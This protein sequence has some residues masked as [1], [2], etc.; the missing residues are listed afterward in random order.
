[1]KKQKNFLISAA[2]MTLSLLAA[3]ASCKQEGDTITNVMNVV[4]G[5]PKE[6]NKNFETRSVPLIRIKDDAVEYTVFMRIYDGNEYV[7]YVGARYWLETVN[8]M[9]I[10]KMDYS[11]GEYTITATAWGKTFPIVINTKNNTMYCPAWGGFTREENGVVFENKKLVE[12]KKTFTGQKSIT[13]DLA[14]YGFKVYGGLDDV[15]VPLCVMNQL[16]T[17]T[18]LNAQVLYNGKNMYQY[19]GAFVYETFPDSPWYGDLNR[20]P[21]TLVETTYNMLCFTHDYIYGKPGYYGFADAGNGR[22]DEEKVKA[23][24]ALSFDAM[25]SLY[26]EDTKGLLLSSSYVDYLKGLARLTLYT[27]GDEHADIEWNRSIVLNSEEINEAVYDVML[28]GKSAKWQYDMKIMS[29]TNKG[30]LNYWRKQKGLLDDNYVLKSDRQLELMD[31]GKVLVIHFD[32]F[33][34]DETGA[35]N[36]YYADN[37]PEEPDPSVLPD[38]TIKLF[39]GAFKKI[40]DDKANGSTDSGTYKDV[41]TV[42][43]DVS[44]N[45]GGKNITLYWL[46]TLL[47]GRGDLTYDDVHTGSKYH[48]YAKADLNFDGNIDDKDESYREFID[49]LNIAILSSFNSFSCG[50]L[51]PYFAKERGIKILGEQSGGGSCSVAIGVTADGFPFTFSRNSRFCNADF[52]KTLE[53]GVEVDYPLMDGDSYEKFFDEDALTAALKDVFG[54]KY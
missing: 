20:R 18:L 21:Q 7:P 17:C 28:N 47:T 13:F 22:P 53:G 40:K 16:F 4:S 54:E 39:Y 6:E 37:T 31:G 24:D 35:W 15:Y 38:D 23:A 10:T 34:Y 30:G 25:L 29:P 1:M 36:A 8:G 43:I 41:K 27:Y 45:G 3:L 19:S 2:V 50:N 48:D 9:N 5:V 49:D 33:D 26:D 12:V 44:C 42:L 11:D 52:T 46:L 32:F 51:L 14:K